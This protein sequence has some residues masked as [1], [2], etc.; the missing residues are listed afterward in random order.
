[1]LIVP[2]PIKD[3]VFQVVENCTLVRETLMKLDKIIRLIFPLF[4]LF[5]CYCYKRAHGCVTS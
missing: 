3:N 5:C 4:S 1:M 2:K